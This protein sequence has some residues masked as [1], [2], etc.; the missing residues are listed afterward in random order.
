MRRLRG[1]GAVHPG[2]GRA[3][4]DR[5]GQPPRRVGRGAAAVSGAG[6]GGGAGGEAD[7][8]R[9]P[10]GG[11]ARGRGRGGRGERAQVEGDGSQESG[12]PHAEPRARR[13]RV[14]ARRALLRLARI[15]SP[16]LVRHP[17]RPWNIFGFVA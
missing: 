6:C 3:G 14:D 2:R 10:L 9:V 13:L 8:V 16:P 4:G 12:A 17:Y 1:A 5:G 7:G 15:P 11:A